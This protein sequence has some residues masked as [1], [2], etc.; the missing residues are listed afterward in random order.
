M[1]KHLK[2]RLGK[3]C[4][5]RWHNHL[6]P[7]VKKSSW[8]AEEDLIIYKAH[9]LLGNRWAEIAK[10]LPGRQVATLPETELGWYELLH[11]NSCSFLNLEKFDAL[12]C[13]SDTL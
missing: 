3:Q 5:E 2:G 4:R 7:S 10:L 1:A 11:A 8:T 6:N 13:L 9:C 12:P